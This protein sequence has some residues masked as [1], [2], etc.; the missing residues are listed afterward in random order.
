MVRL[1]R[2]IIVKKGGV[3]NMETIS[4][5]RKDFVMSNL[6]RQISSLR[7]IMN[8]IEIE[9]RVYLGYADDSLR[10]IEV[11]LRQIRKLCSDN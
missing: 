2:N 11:N 3:K 6:R 4:N 8:T 5:I 10:E 7:N 9:D 1:I